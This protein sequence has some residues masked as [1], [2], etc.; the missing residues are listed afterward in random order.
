[1][2]QP[3]FPDEITASTLQAMPDAVVAVDNHG[4]IRF[5][6]SRAEKLTGYLSDELQGRNVDVLV[7]A[8]RR[9]GHRRN[10]SDYHKA[11]EAREMGD[12]RGLG[13]RRK[14]GIIVPVVISLSP[15]VGSE[16]QIVITTVR[17]VSQIER[18]SKEDILLAEIEALVGMEQDID[19]VYGVLDSLLP[20]M[21]EFDRMVITANTSNDDYVERK[22][23]SGEDVSENGVGTLAA[24]PDIDRSP[25]GEIQHETPNHIDDDSDPDAIAMSDAGL[26]SWLQVPLGDTENP[27]GHLSLRSFN[28]NTYDEDDLKLLERVATRIAPAFENARLYAQVSKEIVERTTLADIGRTVSSSSN[29]AEFFDDFAVL[30]Q[31]LIPFDSMVYSDVDINAGTV[32]LRYWHEV[33]LP[34]QEVLAGVSL[35]GTLTQEAIDAGGPILRPV[36]TGKPIS[37]HSATVSLKFDEELKQ[38]LC[39]PLLTRGEVFG[40]L[41]LGSNSEG[42]FTE[43]HLKMMSLIAS[44]VSGALAN[45]RLHEARIKAE[46]HRLEI[47]SRSRELES[48]HEQRT[49]FL[50]TVSHELKTPLTSLVAFGDILSKNLD[51]NLSD[52]QVQHI[53]VMHR[54][55]R[56]LD[57]LINDLVDVSQLEG[58]TLSVVKTP[59]SVADLLDEIRIAFIPILEPKDQSSFLTSTT[60]DSV[61]LA[62]RDRIAQLLTN[63][64]SNASKYSENGTAIEVDI[65]VDGDMLVLSVTDSGIGMETA[66][67]ENV[68]TPFFRSSDEFTQAQVGTGLGLAIV[69]NI[70]ELHDGT[71]SATSEPGVG[72]TIRVE[73]PRATKNLEVPSIIEAPPTESTESLKSPD[74]AHN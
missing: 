49:D 48:L 43:D 28:E 32:A 64:M 37:D 42:V 52:R 39:V 22:F 65:S 19:R 4:M 27:F 12:R 15:L 59:F 72:T 31:K 18:R 63:L 56:R 58:G 16:D 69:K 23:V 61:I 38:T 46:T 44:Q 73:I 25:R 41:Y 62:D 34:S 51:K 8:S 10:V 5:I 1:M 6:N 71:V 68:F 54:S 26:S 9:G 67:L 45:A 11:P 29:V 60:A 70:V 3:T 33:E 20:V 66:V 74:N 2:T 7:P 57:V 17:D 14:D 21:F 47:E 24:V 35:D 13:L 55:A 53:D 30:V 50:S 40:C 36:K